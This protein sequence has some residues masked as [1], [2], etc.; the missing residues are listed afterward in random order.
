MVTETAHPRRHHYEFAHRALPSIMLSPDVDL[1]RFS[2]DLERLDRALRATWDDVGSR[3]PESDRVAPDGLEVERRSVGGTEGLL[4][5]LPTALNPAEAIF[6][7]V[8]PLDP[9]TGRRFFTLESG[10]DVVNKRTYTV[11]CS[12]TTDRH[13]NHGP[14]P[15]PDP[16]AFVDAVSALM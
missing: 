11:L 15:T 7:L 5:T 3:Q 13:I 6:V 4:I 16:D 14:G 8:V 10:W 1:V 2:G 12:W 9:S